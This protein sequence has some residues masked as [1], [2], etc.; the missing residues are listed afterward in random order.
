VRAGEVLGLLAE[1]WDAHA[2]FMRGL[3]GLEYAEAL[4]RCARELR[5]R[6]VG[7]GGGKALGALAAGWKEE[8]KRR[9]EGGGRDSYAAGLEGCAEELLGEGCWA[10]R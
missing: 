6:E 4:E 10:E 2:R 9:R 1:A 7:K 3:G 8:V 5:E